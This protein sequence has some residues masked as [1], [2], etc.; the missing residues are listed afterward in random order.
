MHSKELSTQKLFP[1]TR[2]KVICNNRSSPET[3]MVL[4][5]SVFQNSSQKNLMP[6]PVTGRWNSDILKFSQ[7]PQD[8][9]VT[10]DIPVL[11]LLIC[12]QSMTPTVL[13]SCSHVIQLPTWPRHHHRITSPY[14]QTLQTSSRA[15]VQVQTDILVTGVLTRDYRTRPRGSCQR[16][17]ILYPLDMVPWAASG[18]VP[19]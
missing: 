15:P 7:F 18:H 1:F 2:S 19:Q 14:W 3:G 12:M 13:S 17:H 4:Q 10:L 5:T 11:Y 6:Q 9:R 8:T 16:P